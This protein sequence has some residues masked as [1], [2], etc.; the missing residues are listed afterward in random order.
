MKLVIATAALV[1]HLGAC[2]LLKRDSDGDPATVTATPTAT[3]TAS[4]TATT[5][6]TTAT[7]A[8]T[9]ATAETVAAGKLPAGWPIY[10]PQYPGSTLIKATSDSDGKYMSLESTDARER[11]VTFYK[12]KLKE[13]GFGK[14]VTAALGGANPSTIVTASKGSDMCS[15][16]VTAIG[17]K[18]KVTISIT[19]H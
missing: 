11:V 18:T 13:S 19:D 14:P 2:K 16:T 6:T 5:M 4:A 15:V 8:A 1:L 10:A 17:G 9:T 7:A 3:A 12:D